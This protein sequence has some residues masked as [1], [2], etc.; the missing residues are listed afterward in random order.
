MTEEGATNTT[1]EERIVAL[2]VA[3]ARALDARADGIAQQARALEDAVLVPE[4]VAELR[5]SVHSL[6]GT[7]GVHGM[8]DVCAA[9]RAMLVRLDG[10][11]ARGPVRDW[12]ETVR[13]LGIMRDT[14]AAAAPTPTSP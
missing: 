13:L 3:F 8:H 5:R 12:E 14:A 2:K 7:S 11:A 1:F 6:V 4:G 9:A 10:Q